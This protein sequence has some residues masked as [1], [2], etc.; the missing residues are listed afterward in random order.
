MQAEQ[1]QCG[2]SELSKRQAS[3]FV[4]LSIIGFQL[5]DYL[6]LY[7]SDPIGV[8]VIQ[9]S[10]LN[11]RQL[12]ERVKGKGKMCQRTV[13]IFR[14]LLKAPPQNF[15]SRLARSHLT[16]LTT[17]LS[18]Q[19]QDAKMQSFSWECKREMERRIHSDRPQPVFAVGSLKSVLEH[20]TH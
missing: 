16:I 8:L 2:S 17:I 11:P 15:P 7:S 12:E 14:S 1:G 5:Q 10:C 19:D 13:F 9:S 20:K 18:S 4:L 3:P 6:I